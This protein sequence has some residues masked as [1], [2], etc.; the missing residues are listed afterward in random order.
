MYAAKD[1]A[2]AAAFQRGESMAGLLSQ[3]LASRV[4]AEAPGSGQGAR[5][6]VGGSREL[7]FVPSGGRGG[8]GRGRGRGRDGGSREGGRNEGGGSMLGGGGSRGRGGGRSGGRG[9]GR[10][11]G[12]G[13]R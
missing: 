1:A 3:P 7:S 4:A 8:R 6:W 9:G 12:R 5:Q 10:G 13:R 2:A 11:R